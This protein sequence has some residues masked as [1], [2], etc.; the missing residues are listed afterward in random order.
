MVSAAILLRLATQTANTIPAVTRVTRT[1]IR[2]PY[3]GNTGKPRESAELRGSRAKR[4]RF[5]VWGGR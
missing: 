2:Y 4:P 5:A 1:M 3:I